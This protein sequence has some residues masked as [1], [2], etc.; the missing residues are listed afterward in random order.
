MHVTSELISFLSYV[1]V[2]LLNLKKINF[3]GTNEDS[4]TNSFLHSS[5]L[6]FRKAKWLKRRG[7][8]LVHLRF[9]IGFDTIRFDSVRFG[10]V[11]FDY[12]DNFRLWIPTC[13]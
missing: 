8:C 12:W 11:R 1:P 9:F 5:F 10:S 7:P 13:S 6:E 4:M 2:I 3:V